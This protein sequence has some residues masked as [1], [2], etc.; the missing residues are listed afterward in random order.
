MRGKR[1][2]GR[3]YPPLRRITPADAGK[4]IRHIS[5]CSISVGS[6]PRMRGKPTETEK[7]HP[8]GRITPADAG[9]TTIPSGVSGVSTDH[10][11]GCGENAKHGGTHH[12]FVGSP[13]RMR[14]KRFQAEKQSQGSRITPADAG[15]TFRRELQKNPCEDHPRGCGENPYVAGIVTCEAGSPPRM[16]GKRK[17]VQKYLHRLRITPADA[18]KTQCYACL[19]QRAEDHPRGCGENSR[20]RNS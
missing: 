16:R 2:R 14:G 11:R 8:R 18:G 15:K 12:G 9:K 7:Q 1:N 5:D 20:T 4:T 6:P 10:P 3:Y 13:P 19:S 17:K